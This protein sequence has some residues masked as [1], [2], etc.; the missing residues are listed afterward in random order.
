MSFFR[1]RFAP[2]PTGNLHLGAARTALFNYLSAK[3]RKGK[4]ILRIED[5]DKA[6]SNK[7]FVK[8]ILESLSWLGLSWNEGPFFQ[9]KRL[10][11]YQR[12]LRV[13][14]K[15]GLAYQR[16]GAWWFKVGE[17]KEGEVRFL[18]LI[19]REISFPLEEIKDFVLFKK[20]K[21]PTFLFAGAIDD[22][23]MKIS[24]VVRGEDHISNTP[25]QILL[26]RA[27]GAKLPSFAHLPLILAPEKTKLSKRTGAIGVLDYRKTGYLPEALLNF[28]AL[29]G[30]H[31]EEESQKEVFSLKKLVSTFDIKK[32]QKSASIFDINKLNYLNAYYIRQLPSRQYLSQLGEWLKRWGGSEK[33]VLRKPFFS[34]AALSVQD[35]LTFWGEF[36]QLAHFYLERPKIQNVQKLVF[37][38]S[39]QKLTLRGLIAALDLLQETGAALWKSPALLA[40]LLKKAVK[41][42][43]LSPGDVFWP[44]RYALSGEEASPPPQVLLSVLG[45]K[46]SLIRIKKSIDLLE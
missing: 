26:Y 46:E 37:K 25:R 12:Y 20:D 41:E 11:I 43:N 24:C 29:L 22:L 30:F 31:P 10:K 42:A 32:V 5:T 13:L 17:V 38:K 35:R 8:N 16:E 14:V 23:E 27:L 44:V 4:L 6:R 33:N 19:R 3:K 45:K 7:V 34:Q 15:K 21:N 9:S 28:L 18:D 1:V 39:D 40:R 36:G 2:S